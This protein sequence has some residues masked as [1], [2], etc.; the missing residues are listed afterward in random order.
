MSVTMIR[1]LGRLGKLGVVVAVLGSV[2]CGTRRDTTTVITDTAA[3][4]PAPTPPPD[5]VRDTVRVPVPTDSVRD[6]TRPPGT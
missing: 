2:G 5:T 3:V 1:N 6:T 4:A